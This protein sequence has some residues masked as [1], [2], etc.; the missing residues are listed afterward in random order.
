MKYRVYR[1]VGT[2]HVK[3]NLSK[4]GISTSVKLGRVTI[5]PQRNR[6]TYNT[7]IKGISLYDN[8]YDE[9]KTTD[10]EDECDVGY[11]AAILFGG[12]ALMILMGFLGI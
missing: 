9:A 3:F 12:I 6:I 4:S 11:I 7:P 2:K 1:R 5:N 8:I 10:D